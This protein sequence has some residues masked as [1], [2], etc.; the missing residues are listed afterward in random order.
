MAV[1]RRPNVDFIDGHQV[2]LG[3]MGGVRVDSYLRAG[4]DVYAAG[5]CAETFDFLG[6]RAI[7]AVIPTAIETGRIAALNMLGFPTPYAGSIN[8]NVLIV[9]GRAFF[10]IGFLD[11]DKVQRKAGDKMHLYT[12]QEGR[13]V[14][15]QFAGEV[16]EAAQAVSAIRRGIQA[17]GIFRFDALRRQLFLPNVFPN[18]NR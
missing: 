4:E 11:G 7:N 2:G 13:L 12:L 5:D 3:E 18:P 8:A 14:G 9:F 15:A 17:K 16:I 1:G 6:R 10:S